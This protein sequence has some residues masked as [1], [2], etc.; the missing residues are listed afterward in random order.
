MDMAAI[1]AS[2]GATE[3]R[4][5]CR[6]AKRLAP[7]TGTS[8]G[9]N[10]FHS[11]IPHDISNSVWD[12]EN[13]EKSKLALIFQCYEAMPCYAFFMYISMNYREFSQGVK[14][15]FWKQFRKYLAGDS[16]L[17]DP[18]AYSLWCDFL[19]A[20][21]RVEEAW[22]ELTRVPTTRNLLRR[23]L[24]A[25]GPVPYSLKEKL[26]PR[27]LPKK[28]W[29]YYIFLSLLHS[30]FDVYGNIDAKKARKMLNRLRLPPDTENLGML[31]GALT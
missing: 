11:D 27:L 1:I 25:S 10:D 22:G 29:H 13:D 24:T 30:R 15:Q 4:K 31:R 7:G 28:E 14:D 2:V 12:E 9:K 6:E 18:A 20:P 21:D 19:E 5:A 3:Y 8:F 26:Y 16:V 23:V 17:A